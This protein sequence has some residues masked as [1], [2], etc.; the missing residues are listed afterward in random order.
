MQH[1]HIY[2][3][4]GKQLCCTQEEKIYTKAGAI[5]LIKEEHHDH[6]GHDHDHEESDDHDHSHG[7]GQSVW[8]QYLPAIASFFM[9]LIGILLDNYVK[10]DF[11]NGYIRLAWYVVAY[12]P[13]GFPVIKEAF[14]T[15]MKGEFF[16]EFTLMVWQRL[17]LL[18]LANIPKVW[19]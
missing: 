13:V 19:Q 4:D 5:S 16:T 12:L 11:F 6:D 1:Q 8:Q 18:L 3:K 14:E 7:E 2:D 17:G 10:Q 15:I 9:L